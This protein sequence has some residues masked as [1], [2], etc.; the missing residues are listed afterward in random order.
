MSAV[1]A[2]LAD[3]LVGRELPGA[4][5]SARGRANGS[6][7]AQLVRTYAAAVGLEELRAVA[8]EDAPALAG[9]CPLVGLRLG[10]APDLAATASADEVTRRFLGRLAEHGPVL[11]LLDEVDSEARTGSR[12]A[13]PHTVASPWWVGDRTRSTRPYPR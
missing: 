6:W 9:I 10:V 4:V 5:L 12:R 8:G 2:E 13:C 7:G 1:L 11:V 3:A